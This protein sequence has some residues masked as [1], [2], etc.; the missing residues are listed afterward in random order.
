MIKKLLGSKPLQVSHLGLGCM[1]MSECYGKTNDLESIKTIHRAIE[2]GITHIDTAD[3][4]GL[5]H[6][7]KLL[8]K[9]L[10]GYRE[11][12][13]LASKCGMVRNLETGE[14]T[15]VNGRSDY[16]KQSC[17]ASLKRLE[18]DYLDLFYLHRADPNTPIEE[19]IG[20]FADLVAE[21]KIRHIGLSEVSAKTIARAQRVH[22]LTAIQSEYSLW[23]RKPEEEII[24]LCQSLNIGF[25]AHGPMGKGFFT[26]AI[27]SI[28][29]LEKNDLR[30]IL[31]RFQAENITHNLQMMQV[32]KEIAHNHGV[33]PGQ[34]A[35]AWVL[36]QA[37]NIVAIAGTKQVAHLEENVN[38]THLKLSPEELSQIEQR[39]PLNFAQGDLLPESFAKFSEQ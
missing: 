21:G 30:R 34:I 22:P 8:A 35:L 17:E 9:A 12:V 4:Y 37:E 1:G 24:P 26:G 7:E 11:K 28:D 31:P 6:N 27:T 15:G 5:G 38:A 14:F 20:A 19:S 10:K 13:V 39:I 36:N 23:H 16:I 3:C 33:T 18:V 2:L 25:V 29:T 32:L